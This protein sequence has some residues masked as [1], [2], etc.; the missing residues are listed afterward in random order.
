LRRFFATLLLIFIFHWIRAPSG[1][2]KRAL[3]E[4]NL[5]K[6]LLEQER[7]R[8][9]KPELVGDIICLEVDA[10]LDQKDGEYDCFLTLSLLMRNNSV[11]PTMVSG[12]SL[13]LIWKD[14]D[15]PAV[16]Q[17]LDFYAVQRHSRELEGFTTRTDSLTDFPYGEEITNTNYKIGWL[18]FSVGAVPL[19]AVKGERLREENN[20]EANRTR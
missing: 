1:F 8:N 20:D 19:D 15:Y 7:S 11:T 10:N 4:A 16:K 13:E 12:F 14:Q 17:S 18:R 3:V 5:A 9:A 2:Y 6:L